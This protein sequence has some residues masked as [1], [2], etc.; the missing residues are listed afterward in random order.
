MRA[1]TRPPN[2]PSAA[3]GAKLDRQYFLQLSWRALL[4]LAS[5]RSLLDR[6]ANAHVGAAAADISR[7]RGVD[8]R[9]IRIGRRREQGRG[10]HDLARLAIAALDH[11]KVEPGFL[12][13]GASGPSADAL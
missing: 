12:H 2:R 13:L 11:F 6:R 1:E 3:R 4:R 10:R 9:I 7:H 5:G 8:V